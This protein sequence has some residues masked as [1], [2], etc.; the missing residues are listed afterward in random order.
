[1]TGPAKQKGMHMT[2]G[3]SSARHDGI[4]VGFEELAIPRFDSVY[5]FAHWLVQDKDDA[6]DL[7]QETYLKALRGFGEI[8]TGQKNFCDQA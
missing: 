5:N 3:T 4:P 6:E 8:F 1:M 2:I 7:V